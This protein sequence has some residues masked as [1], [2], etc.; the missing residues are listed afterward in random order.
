[1][2]DFAKTLVRIVSTVAENFIAIQNRVQKVDDLKV[3]IDIDL[4][5]SSLKPQI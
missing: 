4:I 3:I 2:V 1:M 5:V